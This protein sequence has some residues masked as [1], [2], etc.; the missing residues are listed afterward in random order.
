[1]S[2]MA[3]LIVES[4]QVRTL[5]IKIVEW[6]QS[7]KNLSTFPFI[8][9]FHVVEHLPNDLVSPIDISKA[10]QEILDFYILPE[11]WSCIQNAQ[12]GDCWDD[13]GARTFPGTS[14]GTYEGLLCILKVVVKEAQLKLWQAQ[15][16]RV[17][18]SRVLVKY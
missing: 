15:Q 8:W 7:K 10:I 9:F 4:A 13:V 2:K 14:K 12:I 11:V 5:F 3:I 16:D 1:M 17:R 18:W 6:K